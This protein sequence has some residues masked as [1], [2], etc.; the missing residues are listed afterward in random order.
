MLFTKLFYWAGEGEREGGGGGWRKDGEVGRR[1]EAVGNK[2]RENFPTDPQQRSYRY[3]SERE[4][5]LVIIQR[6][7]KLAP[8]LKEQVPICCTSVKTQEEFER[9]AK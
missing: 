3:L 9:K 4:E 8:T 1:G 6:L 2:K 5:T 7:S